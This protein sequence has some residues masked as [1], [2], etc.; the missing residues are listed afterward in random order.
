MTN[1]KTIIYR[2]YYE[3]NKEKRFLLGTKGKK[4]LLVIGLN[5]SVADRETNDLTIKKVSTFAERNSFDSF[6]MLNLYAQR[7]TYPNHLHQELDIQLHNENLK[8]VLQIV[9]IKDNVS[10]LAAWGEK[11]IIRN[12]FPLCLQSIYEAIG[13][14][15]FEWFKIGEKSTNSGHPRHPSR[16]SYSNALTPFDITTYIKWITDKNASKQQI[17]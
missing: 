12:Y 4:T 10:I 9:S 2:E 8:H 14:S 15:K 7:T 1:N 6:I 11:I 3:G 17:K 13:K 5:P 16:M